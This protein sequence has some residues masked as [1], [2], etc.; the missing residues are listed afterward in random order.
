[1]NKL[2]FKKGGVEAPPPEMQI[3][4]KWLIQNY[5]DLKDF[6]KRF[7]ILHHPKIMLILLFIAAQN[8]PSVLGLIYFMVALIFAP[9]PNVA[10]HSWFFLSFYSQ[11]FVLVQY[12][13]QF[14]FFKVWFKCPGGTEY[15]KWLYWA[16]LHVLGS[17]E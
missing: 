4:P 11:I 12:I 2:I 13:Y 5:N 15:C 16:G 10:A 9:M 6:L 17:S 8:H 1:S 14:P 7:S 3:L